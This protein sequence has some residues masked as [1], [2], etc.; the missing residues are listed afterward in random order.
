MFLGFVNIGLLSGRGSG[1]IE[2]SLV[3]RVKLLYSAV[4]EM[5]LIPLNFGSA[6]STAFILRNMRL[7]IET[8]AADST[9]TAILVNFG[10]WGLIVLLFIYVYPLYVSLKNYD[11]K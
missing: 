4:S 2:G 6:T 11:K 5:S 9:I 3:Q 1:I 8:I 7:N 10:L